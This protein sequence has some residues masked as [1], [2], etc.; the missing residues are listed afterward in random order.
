MEDLGELFD[1]AVEDVK[2]VFKGKI[3]N[4]KT[5]AEQAKIK[6]GTVMVVL[7][8]TKKEPKKVQLPQFRWFHR[9]SKLCREQG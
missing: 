6:S 7:S 9:R 1:V 5:T 3:L 4:W 8:K 2:L